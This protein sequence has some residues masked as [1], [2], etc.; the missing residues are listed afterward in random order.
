M[1]AAPAVPLGLNG[2]RVSEACGANIE[3]LA[4]QRGH[5]TLA[6]VGKG[7]KPAVI[8]GSTARTIDLA[9]GE[10]HEGPI[11]C[12]R[13]GQ[14]VDRRTADRWV[15]SIGRREELARCIRTCCGP[16]SSW[17]PW[18]PGCR[19]GMSRSPPVT[20]TRTTTIYDRRR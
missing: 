9:V 12:R 20:P 11:L 15:R 13:D 4:V 2:L 3:D 10:R 14:R 8:P 7:N 17:P 19:C 18:M 1:H 5:R 6:I 16:G